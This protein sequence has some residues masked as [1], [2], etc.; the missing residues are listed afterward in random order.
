MLHMLKLSKCV[1]ALEKVWIYAIRVSVKSHTQFSALILTFTHKTSFDNLTE[2]QS[3]IDLDG[4]D[5][6][7]ATTKV[8]IPQGDG[9]IEATSTIEAVPNS[10]LYT[11]FNRIDATEQQYDNVK[12]DEKKIPEP[13]ITPQRRSM[14]LQEEYPMPSAPTLQEMSNNPKLL[15]N[16]QGRQHEFS[17]RTVLRSES[18]SY[19]LKK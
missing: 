5:K 16:L 6:I 3:I 10:A 12:K 4:S 15:L 2:N 17:S 19:C 11:Q 8:S 9:P 7:V 1:E 18:C 13:F 14:K